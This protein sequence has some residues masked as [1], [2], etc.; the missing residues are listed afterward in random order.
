MFT[1]SISKLLLTVLVGAVAWRGWRI[2]QQVQ[3]RVAA[4]SQQ[5]AR[6][7]TAAGAQA[8]A[9]P[10]A[11]DLVECVRCGMFVPNGTVCRS[12]EECR[13]RRG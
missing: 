8:A 11:T 2:Y 1:I 13:F 6:A 3:E 7:R 9:A 12:T 4:A 5:A 10:R